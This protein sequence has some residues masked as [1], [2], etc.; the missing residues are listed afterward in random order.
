MPLGALENADRL[1][2]GRFEKHVRRLLTHLGVEAAHD[3][4]ECDC[5]FTVGDDE[6]HWVELPKCPVE[7]REPPPRPRPP[8]D[9]A[10]AAGS[11]EVETVQRV[12]EGMHDV[13]GHVDGVRDRT[14]A[15]RYEARLEP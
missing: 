3:P 14:H 9:E 6:V 7:A 12:A 1:E 5:T 8:D 11:G 15:R 13:V 4:G 2:I 10:P